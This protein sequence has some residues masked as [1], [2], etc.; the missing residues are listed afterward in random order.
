MMVCSAQSAALDQM[1][2]KFFWVLGESWT[3]S[4]KQLMLKTLDVLL[5]HHLYLVAT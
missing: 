1:K 2:R 4:F 5:L 3:V